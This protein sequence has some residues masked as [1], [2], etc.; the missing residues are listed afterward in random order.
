MRR[1]ADAV[2][3]DRVPGLRAAMRNNDIMLFL[4]DGALRELPDDKQR[5]VDTVVCNF[6]H[7]AWRKRQKLWRSACAEGNDWRLK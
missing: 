7:V 1:I 3:G 6:L 4:G 5:A 2:S